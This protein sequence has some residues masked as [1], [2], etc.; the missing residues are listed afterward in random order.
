MPKHVKFH[1]PILLASFCGQTLNFIVHGAEGGV[2]HG[3]SYHQVRLWLEGRWKSKTNSQKLR[4]HGQT[5]SPLMQERRSLFHLYALLA[6][7]ALVCDTGSAWQYFQAKN[8][9]HRSMQSKEQE[10]DIAGLW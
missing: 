1:W 2:L 6:I 9:N 4:P 3:R 8:V 7:T 5:S 10:R